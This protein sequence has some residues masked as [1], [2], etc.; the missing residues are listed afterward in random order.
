MDGQIDR[1]IVRQ[2]RQVDR[3]VDRQLDRQIDHSYP[4]PEET[5]SISHLEGGAN[6]TTFCETPS[7]QSFNAAVAVT[8]KM[9]V[10]MTTSPARFTTLEGVPKPWD[11]IPWDIMTKTN[12]THT[13]T[14]YIYISLKVPR[15]YFLSPQEKCHKKGSSPRNHSNA[16]VLR[17]RVYSNVVGFYGRGFVA[18]SWF[19]RPRVYSNG[20]LASMTP[21]CLKSKCDACT[22]DFSRFSHDFRSLYCT[23]QGLNR[24]FLVL[25]EGLLTKT[26]DFS[27][28]QIC[29][30]FGHDYS[31]LYSMLQPR[32]F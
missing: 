15:P 22:H 32:F 16:E 31:I 18:M 29:P 11:W 21:M 26:H 8:E 17:P 24:S 1:Q 6:A 20:C 28:F 3:Q 4:R 19:L 2:G 30:H 5:Q 27:R 13:H 14:I 7:R 25:L 10:M 23:F 12:K 9:A